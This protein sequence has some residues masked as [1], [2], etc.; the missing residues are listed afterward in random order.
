MRKEDFWKEVGAAPFEAWFM[1]PKC[2]SIPGMAM[3]RRIG[4]QVEG[5]VPARLARFA[6]MPID[7]PAGAAPIFRPVDFV[8]KVG[9]GKSLSADLDAAEARAAFESL[10]A[11]AFA[12]S[13]LGA[14]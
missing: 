9:K 5:P 14:F 12:P 6:P 2:V 11:G 4:M 13:Q 3:R 8:K 1:P 10:L 7:A